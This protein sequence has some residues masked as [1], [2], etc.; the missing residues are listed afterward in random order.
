MVRLEN[1]FAIEVVKFSERSQFL[2]TSPVAEAGWWAGR[3]C[4]SPQFIF[5]AGHRY[6]LRARIKLVKY[7]WPRKSFNLPEGHLKIP[8]LR[9]NLRLGFI[10]A[11][12]FFSSRLDSKAAKMP[13]LSLISMTENL[14]NF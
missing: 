8:N 10:Y 12:S 5:L 14:L 11:S 1:R 3:Q 6:V 2:E 4:C 7:L 9:K 13:E